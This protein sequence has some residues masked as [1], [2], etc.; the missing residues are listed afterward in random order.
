MRLA[1]RDTTEVCHI[2]EVV[3]VLVLVQFRTIFLLE[4]LAIFSQY[5]I[6][7]LVILAILR[8]LVDKEELEALDATVEEGTLLAEMRLDGFSYL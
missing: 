2:V 6:A 7:I 1:D 3:H 4:Y 8:H 5:G